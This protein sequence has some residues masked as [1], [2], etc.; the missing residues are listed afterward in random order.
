MGH[1]SVQAFLCGAH[2][3]HNRGSLRHARSQNVLKCSHLASR[4]LLPSNQSRSPIIHAVC[5]NLAY[6]VVCS[7]ARS[8]LPV[9]LLTKKPGGRGARQGHRRTGQSVCELV[10]G[11]K[12]A[13]Q[14]AAGS[15]QDS[16]RRRSRA[17]DSERIGQ[18][19]P[20]RAMRCQADQGTCAPGTESHAGEAGRP[21]SA[22]ATITTPSGG[23]RSVP[24]HLRPRSLCRQA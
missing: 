13:Q 8:R 24:G 23:L 21:Q 6:P 9:G 12:R 14:I 1:R 10:C 15:G 3:G 5:R 17:C 20:R 16:D 11:C 22:P 4:V 19:A 18:L 7:R 2:G